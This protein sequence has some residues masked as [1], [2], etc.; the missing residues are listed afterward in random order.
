MKLTSNCRR[1]SIYEIGIKLKNKALSTPFV[2]NAGRLTST[3]ELVNYTRTI[4]IH[5]QNQRAN[6]THTYSM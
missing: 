2:C 1:R 4:F 3:V 5:H 6:T